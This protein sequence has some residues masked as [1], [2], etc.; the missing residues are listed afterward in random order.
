VATFGINKLQLGT[1]AANYDELIVHLDEDDRAI[2]DDSTEGFLKLYL[3]K[4]GLV[5]GG[6]MVGPRA[7]EITS[8]LILMMYEGI[9]LDAVLSKPF[10]YP[11]GSRV[12][13]AAARQY[14]GKKL[15]SPF[16]KRILRLLYH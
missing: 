3:S 4:Q 10:P 2:T 13:Q 9:K 11:I 1:E 14:S 8:E 5:L 7:G 15:Q 12:I 6:T 16:A